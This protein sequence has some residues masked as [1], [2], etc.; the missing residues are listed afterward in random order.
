MFSEN[1]FVRVSQKKKLVMF[2]R[3]TD[4]MTKIAVSFL[5]VQQCHSL[6]V[7]TKVQRVEVESA[8]SKSALKDASVQNEQLRLQMELLQEEQK[9]QATQQQDA[10]AR[11]KAELQEHIAL[12]NAK[13]QKHV[14]II[15]ARS[16]GFAI[17]EFLTREGTKL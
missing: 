13:V 3:I 9:Q 12:L 17:C 14:F 4:A 11:E 1:I 15:P 7:V 6:Q 16:A 5:R 2:T 10:A 8:Q